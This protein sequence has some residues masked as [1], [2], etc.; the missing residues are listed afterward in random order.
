MIWY[1]KLAPQSAEGAGVGG[2]GVVFY[3]LEGI[4]LA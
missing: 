1:Q 3:F 4:F 2:R